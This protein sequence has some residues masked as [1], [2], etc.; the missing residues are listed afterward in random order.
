MAE[1]KQRLN[2]IV[3]VFLEGI[4]DENSELFKL[5]AFWYIKRKIWRYVK[6][7]WKSSIKINPAFD[8]RARSFETER[9][10]I[11][12][13]SRSYMN[14]SIYVDYREYPYIYRDVVFPKPKGININMMPFVMDGM[15][16]QNFEKC[17]LPSSLKT[18]WQNIIRH[19]P[20]EREQIGKIGYLTIQENFVPKQSS[21]RR[22][23]IHTER[24]GLVRL[25]NKKTYSDGS[26]SE[27]CDD[28]APE[29]EDDLEFGNGYSMVRRHSWGW[30]AGNWRPVSETPEIQGGIYMA[31]N[32]SDSCKIY[33]CEILNDELIGEH[34]D[35]EH[36]REFLP[37]GEVLEKNS[38]YWFTDR[39]PHESLPLKKSAE[40][41]FFRLVTS[42]VSLWF[43]E[44][45]TKNPL[46]VVPDPEKTKI[47]KGYK[48]DKN[49]VEIWTLC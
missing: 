45:S 20:L 37:E 28:D 17:C 35:I 7:F 3:K 21:Q 15:E 12:L 29:V 44:H 11:N 6:N 31:S 22:P 46:G 30:G 19:C 43:E 18:Y 36:L 34:G 42:E 32:V 8:P 16:E 5:N 23:G 25:K 2:P 41:Q 14:E 1:P 26:H 9:S 33:N 39:T 4:Y 40:R 27:S 38:I 13:N 48:F 49:G 47:V 24:P 10:Y